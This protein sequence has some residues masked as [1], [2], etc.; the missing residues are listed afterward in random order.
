MDKIELLNDLIA[1]FKAQVETC[2]LIETRIVDAFVIMLPEDGSMLTQ[3]GVRPVYKT[4]NEFERSRDKAAVAKLLAQVK[5]DNPD[6]PVVQR[7]VIG[8]FK[9]AAR[10]QRLAGEE[11][12]VDLEKKLAED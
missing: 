5:A 4:V 7:L 3:N 9:K 8:T 1:S 10:Q 6:N 12:L 11:M 2:R